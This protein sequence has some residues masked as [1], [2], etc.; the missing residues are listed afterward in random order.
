MRNSK[1]P[2]E[3][4]GLTDRRP[5][6][7]SFEALHARL[8]PPPFPSRS[9]QSSGLD[10][11][12]GPLHTAQGPHHYVTRCRMTNIDLGTAGLFTEHLIYVSLLVL[13]SR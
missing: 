2:S 8:G 10:I 11:Y 12:I 6:G 9:L 5:G 4:E 3:H 1:E 7:L 13:S